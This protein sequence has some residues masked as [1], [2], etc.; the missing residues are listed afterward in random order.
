V[1]K[2]QEKSGPRITKRS[3]NDVFFESIPSNAGLQSKHNEGFDPEPNEGA[4]GS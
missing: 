4:I 3:D 2:S 1:I